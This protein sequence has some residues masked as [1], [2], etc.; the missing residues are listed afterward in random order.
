MKDRPSCIVIGAGLAGLA[1]GYELVEAGWKVTVLEAD[2]RV[3]GRVFTHRFDGVP[4]AEK[5]VCELGAEW[6]GKEHQRLKAL[7]STFRLRPL[8]KHQF[9]FSFWKGTP[10]SRTRTFGPG[11]WCF[12]KAAQPKF[13]RFRSRF[14]RLQEQEKRDLDRYDWWTALRMHGFTTDDLVYRDLMDS[15]DSGES[16]RLSSAYLAATEYFAPTTT[17]E[18]DYKIVGGNDRLPKALAGAIGRRGSVRT[19]AT[20]TRIEQHDG[21]VSVYVRGRTTPFRARY[22]ICSVPTR[23]LTKIRWEPTLPPAQRAAANQL[24]YSRIMKTAVLCAE[25]FWQDRRRYGFAVYTSRASDFCFDSTFGQEGTMGILCSYAIGEKAD[26]LAAESEDLLG[27]WITQDVSEAAE[28]TKDR[29]VAPLRVKKMAWQCEPSGGAYAFYRPG[30]WFDI[31]P[32]LSQPHGR[33]WFAGEHLSGEW[34][35]FMEGAVETGQ[36]AA[37]AVIKDA[38]QA[39]R[40]SRAR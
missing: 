6:I 9:T 7:C 36:N 23:A 16:I 11:E 37:K 28:P 4:G 26:N 15:T 14:S 12:S 29:A 20:V 27:K 5:L 35:G 24:Q 39:R 32:I 22:C 38:R 31:Q 33:V 34:Q 19:E 2:D 1:A 18:M 10:E 25:R 8:K 3:G 30:Q 13:R 17:N 40:R 21:H